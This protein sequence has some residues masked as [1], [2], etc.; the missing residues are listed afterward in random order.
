VSGHS[1]P[2]AQRVRS[3]GHEGGATQRFSF[4]ACIDYDTLMQELGA[5][6]KRL[7]ATLGLSQLDVAKG[8]GVARPNVAAVEAGRRMPRFDTAVRLIEAAGGRL[9]VEEP[10]AWTWVEGRRP[11]A[12]ATRLWR[13][14]PSEALA[15][16][17]PGLALWWS[18]PRRRFDM[19]DRS[20]RAR[21]Y[22]IVLREGGPDDISAIVDG[23]LL[24]ELWSELVLPR[25]LRA[26]WDPVVRAAL[27]GGRRTVA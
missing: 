13:L 17:E 8:S 20:D 26:S 2:C 25:D 5:T 18:S 21:L 23:V 14:D 6:L 7:R 4:S 27:V 16:V 12:V 9:E 24:C 15:T 3:E 10:V 11:Y 22:E 1:R 19:A